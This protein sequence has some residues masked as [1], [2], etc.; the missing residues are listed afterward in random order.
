MRVVVEKKPGNDK[1]R[2]STISGQYSGKQPVLRPF[3]SLNI[4]GKIQSKPLCPCG[5]GCPR[6]SGVIQ[7]KLKIGQPNDIY[8]QEADRI[9]DQVMRMPEPTVQAK[10]T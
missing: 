9:A 2:G 1:Q 3:V 5:G 6:C 4:S 8:E 10:P 7:A